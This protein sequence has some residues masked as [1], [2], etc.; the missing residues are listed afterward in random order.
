MTASSETSCHPI[1]WI[2]GKGRR[3]KS[4]KYLKWT[5]VWNSCGCNNFTNLCYNIPIDGRFTLGKRLKI[6]AFKRRKSVFERD[7]F[8]CQVCLRRGIFLNAH[9]IKY[10]SECKELRYELSNGITL[11]RTCHKLVHRGIIELLHTRLLG[12]GVRI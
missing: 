9:H 4:G 3:M 5:G 1:E 7:N 8:I 2:Y 11:C 6:M 12:L 10:W